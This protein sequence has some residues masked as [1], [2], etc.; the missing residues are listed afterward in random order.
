MNPIPR[1]KARKFALQALYQWHLTKD[2]IVKIEEQFLTKDIKDLTKVDVVYFNELLRGVPTNLDSIDSAIQPY[3]KRG[4]KEVD[5]I[6]L[7][8]LRIA[9]YELSHRPDIPF[10]VV[11]NEALD[12]TKTFGSEEGYK[13][14]NS[15]LD[16]AAN[17][18]RVAEISQ[19]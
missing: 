15:V 8:V 9:F 6:E 16:R 13:F 1:Q 5:P 19:K 17:E 18:L 3:L 2:D 12:L 7:S 10:K 14:I 4:I 11:I